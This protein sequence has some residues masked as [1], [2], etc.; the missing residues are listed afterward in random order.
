MIMQSGLTPEP[1]VTRKGDPRCRQHV[2][3]LRNSPTLLCT[4]TA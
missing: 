1:K 3:M 4:A 2:Q